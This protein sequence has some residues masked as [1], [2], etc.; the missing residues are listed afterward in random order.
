LIGLVANS[1]KLPRQV[2]IIPVAGLVTLIAITALVGYIGDLP[3]K[4]VGAISKRVSA[5]A[6]GA[7]DGDVLQGRRL[8]KKTASNI[9]FLCFPLALMSTVI[10]LQYLRSHN[11][12]WAGHNAANAAVSSICAS[13]AVAL[14][15][16]GS[17]LVIGVR[18]RLSFSAIGVRIHD[19][20][21]E[22]A[23]SWDDVLNMYTESSWLTPWLVAELPPKSPLRFRGPLAARRDRENV[24]RICDLNRYSISR[25]AV[26][27]ALEFWA[28]FR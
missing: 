26:D 16:V 8:R 19:E 25:S 24:I 7:P 15:V 23:I 28:P 17:Y 12:I 6:S 22:F 3:P 2:F 18:A 4:Q 9:G 20:R 5:L 21:G 1:V 14:I 13:I 27:G 10:S 11:S